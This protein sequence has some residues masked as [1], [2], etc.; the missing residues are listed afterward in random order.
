MM[1][2]FGSLEEFQEEFRDI[3]QEEQVGRLHKMLAP[4]LL[5]SKLLGEGKRKKKKTSLSEEDDDLL[6]FFLCYF[7]NFS[8]LYNFFHPCC[9]MQFQRTFKILSFGEKTSFL[10]LLLSSISVMGNSPD[11]VSV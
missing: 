3:N 5:R 8:F 1:Q 10:L 9:F 4:H 2:Q 7:G 11:W 6:S